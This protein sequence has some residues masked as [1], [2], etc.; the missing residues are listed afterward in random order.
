MMY[1][2]NSYFT[3]SMTV[4]DVNVTTLINF[5]NQKITGVAALTIGLLYHRVYV[6]AWDKYQK[7]PQGKF[8]Q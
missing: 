2:I 5:W 3:P 1:I 4:T 6:T 7:K 8:A